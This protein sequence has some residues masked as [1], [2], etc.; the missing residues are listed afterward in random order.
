[1]VE[2]CK[3]RLIAE[4][5]SFSEVDLAEIHAELAGRLQHAQ[6]NV[7]SLEGQMRLATALRTIDTAVL[8]TSLREARGQ[9]DK[10]VAE[11][12]SANPNFGG[13]LKTVAGIV[14]QIPAGGA[15]VAFDVTK[16][17]S[18]VFTVPAGTR[19]LQPANITDI[20]DF[21]SETLDRLL[22]EQSPH[23]WIA[24]VKAT[25]EL[26]T[27]QQFREWLGYQNG[28]MNALWN[29]LIG[30][31]YAKLCELGIAPGAPVLL[32][33]QGGLW[34]LALHAASRLVDG[35]Q[36]AFADDFVITY[37]PSIY[38]RKICLTRSVD[39]KDE[40]PTLLAVI[41]P[42]G[43]LP[44]AEKEV[45]LISQ[46]FQD[47]ILLHGKEATLK[48][49]SRLVGSAS[50]LHFSCH[51]F[52]DW[53]DTMLS[54]LQLAQPDH[55]LLSEILAKFSLNKN[56]LVTLSACETGII[57]L[58]GAADEF[59]GLPTGFLVAG[60]YGVITTLWKV[61]DAA[62]C[63]LVSALYEHHLANH[64]LP[65][66][67][68]LRAAQ[69]WLRELTL[70]KIYAIKDIDGEAIQVRYHKWIGDIAP[71]DK[72]FDNPFFWAGF[73]YVGG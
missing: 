68:A 27:P 67:E 37:T 61:D 1:M 10:I 70:E 62:S 59:V 73:A 42:N 2:S 51:G 24:L 66:A 28:F 50:Y 19:Q 18:V 36:R 6:E 46:H 72:I 38:A 71:D 25:A 15:L 69:K 21:T 35:V 53:S 11:I 32:L 22:D 49:V 33:P 58:R 29:S 44:Y 4:K 57:D 43:D 3:A 12:R 13:K 40:P 64:N 39:R 8:G 55:L 54:G 14:E 56:R 31:V 45:A 17:G 52:H 48:N 41:D 65:P 23:S 9:L 30:P 60:A 5:L 26:E 20:P 47:P 16:F 7:R 34:L 63:L